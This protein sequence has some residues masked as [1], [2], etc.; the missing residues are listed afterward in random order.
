MRIRATKP[1]FWRSKTIARFDWDTRLILKALESY[2]DDNGVGKDSVIVFCADAFPHDIANSPEIFAKVSRSL[3]KLAEADLIVRYIVAGEDLVYVRHW[4][5]WQYIDKPKAGRYP[6][7]DGTM[8][9]RDT[10]DETIGAGQGITDPEPREVAPEP[11]EDCAKTARRLPEECP[12]I[13][14]G[15]QRNR[16][17]KERETREP[18]PPPLSTIPDD[19][20]PNLSHQAKARSFGVKDIEAAAEAFRNHALAQG[21]VLANWDAGFAQWLASPKTSAAERERNTANGQK[22]AAS[23]LAMAAVEALRHSPTQRLELE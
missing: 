1:E 13:Q 10:V 9:Y 4:K 19:W 2:V 14:S 3:G 15:E 12:Q 7:P 20:A 22:P 6:R 23:D 18:I 11:T 5:R 21:R 17:L 16:D 8:N